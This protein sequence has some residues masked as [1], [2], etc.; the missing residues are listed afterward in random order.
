MAAVCYGP[1]FLLKYLTGLVEKVHAAKQEHEHPSLTNV[2]LRVDQPES[3]I[4]SPLEWIFQA[5]IKWI[6]HFLNLI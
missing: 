2:T 4:F 6:S 3:L 1:N 5:F